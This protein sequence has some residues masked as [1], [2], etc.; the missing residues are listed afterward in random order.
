MAKQVKR[1]L[2]RQLTKL[3]QQLRDS[4][5]RDR[6]VHK[7]RVQMK[8][9]RALLQLMRPVL[10]ESDYEAG[11]EAAKQLADSLA[12]S[13]DAKVMLDTLARLFGDYGHREL[14]QRLETPLVHYYRQQRRKPIA[15][16]SL[17]D[18]LQRQ[19]QKL[20]LKRFDAETVQLALERS[21]GRGRRQWKLLQLELDDTRLH[22]WRKSVK[23]LLYQMELLLPEPCRRDRGDL[24]RLGLLLGQL[25]DLHMLRDL[26]QQQRILVWQD[27][28]PTV[29]ALIRQR[30]A[31]LLADAWPLARKLY[32]RPVKAFSRRMMALWRRG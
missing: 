3:E 25:H 6:A 18:N 22:N 29:N 28:L 14:R 21:Y 4:A 15:T 12:G 11:N 7:V 9:L 8:K 23:R 27:D 31:A 20:P 32:R 2:Q 24:K 5:H 26:L 19:Y 16:E 1:R 17:L 30:E 10:T 13:R